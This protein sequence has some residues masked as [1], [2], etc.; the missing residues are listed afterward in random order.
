MTA[1]R[2]VFE[3]GA[4]SVRGSSM[5][6]GEVAR[7]TI[8]PRTGN[9]HVA[10]CL[11]ATWRSYASPGQRPGYGYDKNHQALKGRTSWPGEVLDARR[12]DNAP[13]VGLKSSRVILN[14]GGRQG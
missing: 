1:T 6:C 14:G 10:M 9:K 2:H 5:S 11:A 8:S 3:A 7:V 13:R 12:I 4:L